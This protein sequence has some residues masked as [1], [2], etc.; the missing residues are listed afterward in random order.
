MNKDDFKKASEII[1][2]KYILKHSSDEISIP[3]KILYYEFLN[4]VEVW[5]HL[6]LY[7]MDVYPKESFES[8]SQFNLHFLYYIKDN[9]V[10]EYINEFLNSIEPFI[11]QN[12]VS[13]IYLMIIDDDNNDIKD[14]FFLD[15]IF[16]QY[17]NFSNNLHQNLKMCF[18]SILSDFYYKIINKKKEKINDANTSFSLC[19][20]LNDNKIIKGKKL[21]NELNQNINT[22]FI[23]DLISK[24]FLKIVSYKKIYSTIENS[25]LKIIINHHTKNKIIE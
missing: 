19:I 3:F 8:F 17:L 5:I 1:D 2:D 7:A 11:F 12:L 20:E 24:D 22:K 10:N 25:N 9:E 6:V 23:H 13:K 18:K 4:F 14:I 21:Y 15:I 16:T